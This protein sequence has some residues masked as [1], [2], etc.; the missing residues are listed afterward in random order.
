MKTQLLGILVSMLMFATTFSVAVPIND[1]QQIDKSSIDSSSSIANGDLSY[2]GARKLVRAS[3]GTLYTVYSRIVNT[4]NNIFCSYSTDL[5]VSWHEMKITN[6]SIYNQNYPSIAIDSKNYLH[7]VWNGPNGTTSNLQIRYTMYDGSTWSPIVNLTSEPTSPQKTPCIAVDGTDK[8]H[9]VWGTNLYQLRYICKTGTSWGTIVIIIPSTGDHTNRNIPSIAV[10]ASNNLHVVCTGGYDIS[11]VSR[12][13]STWGSVVTISKPSPS[14]NHYSPCIVVDSLGTVHVIW[15]GPYPG[16]LGIYQIRYIKKVG[17]TWSPIENLTHETMFD[18]GLY[19]SVAVDGNNNLYVVW[20]GK[21]AASNIY[22]QIRLRKY[23][24]STWSPT[25]NLTSGNITHQLPNL[26]CSVYPRIYGAHSNVPKTGFAFVYQNGTMVTYYTSEDLTWS[27]NLPPGT[28]DK[29]EGPTEGLINKDYTFTSRSIDPDGG[30]V[31]YK[32]KLGTTETTW[33]GPYDSGIDVEA[34]RN[35]TAPGIYQVKVKSK[36]QYVESTWSEPLNITIRQIKLGIT[37][38]TGGVGITTVIKN[39][40]DTPA[41]NVTLDIT[42]ANGYVT[43][44]QKTVTISGIPINESVT[45][46]MPVFGIGLGALGPM[47]K[48]TVTAGT[49]EIDPIQK[50]AS[51]GI[52]LF[53][54]SI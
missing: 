47:P 10:D 18:V 52:F 42:V 9:V 50:E 33:L 8:V 21:T 35:W 51:A 46:K 13:G 7:V 6:D 30:Q 24:G 40:G 1:T 11:Y 15:R 3:D 44:R 25:V 22:D 5:G 19:S 53:F 48:I 14:S 54:V 32:W 2:S 41:F 4:K 37:S 31:W 27:S 29:P 26:I 39:T 38:I 23:D 28:P 45:I 16:G 43:P 12:T 17:S 34:T 49:P 20:Q 36:D